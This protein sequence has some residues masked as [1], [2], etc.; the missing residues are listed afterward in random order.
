MVPMIPVLTATAAK[1]RELYVRQVRG[2]CQ[3]AIGVGA[4]GLAAGA[5]L[6]PDL[7]HLLYRGRY[8]EGPLSCVNAFRWLAVALG[9]VCLTTV[10]TAAML[11]DRKEKTLLAIGTTALVVNAAVNLIALRYYNFTVAGFA[12]AL[13]EFLFLVSALVA[14]QTITRRSALT[15]SAAIYLAP[16]LMLA[17]MLHFVRGGPALRVTCG[18]VVGGLAVASMLLSEGARRF[19]QEIAAGAPTF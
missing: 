9:Q 1:S 11:A 10:L 16:G 7:V 14:F 12:T 2:A 8:L 5:M 3:L 17:T 4:C 13:T 18:I 19:R 6:A 15:W